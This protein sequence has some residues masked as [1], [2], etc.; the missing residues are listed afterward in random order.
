[1]Q[2]PRCLFASLSPVCLVLAL[3]AATI[4]LENGLPQAKA[5]GSDEM[6]K[7]IVAAQIR[8]QGFGCDKPQSATRDETLSRPDEAVWILT[9]EK[10]TYQVRL[11]PHK[12]ARVQQLD[13]K[14]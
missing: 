1:M 14:K 5:Q 13:Q 2:M 10:A 11:I 6:P 9:C 4:F 12:A 3:P 7:E 8:A